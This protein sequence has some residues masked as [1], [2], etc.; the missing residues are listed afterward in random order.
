MKRLTYVVA[1]VAIGTLSLTAGCGAPNASASLAKPVATPP[2]AAASQSSAETQPAA[3]APAVEQLA[4]FFTQSQ[5]MDVRLRHAA[6]L[7]N[8]GFIGQT[9]Q[10]DRA[11][12]AA[13]RDI[14]PL[15]LVRTIPGGLDRDLQRSILLVYN[16]LVSRRAA[17]NGVIEYASTRPLRRDGAEARELLACLANGS[18]AAA[19]F[20]KHLAAARTAASA[21]TLTA[22]APSS[23]QTAEVAILATYI[24]GFN[25]GCASC[26][27]QV[28]GD[29]PPVTWKNTTQLGTR[30]DGTVGNILFQ[31]RYQA[32]QDWTINLNAC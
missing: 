31:A 15:T 19:T 28:L 14:E 2:P 27:G 24:Y 29:L 23:R 7:I 16:D 21:A 22:A 3:P 10:M 9:V 1:A 12:I 18:R 11:S 20:K 30:Y 17:M 32:T 6:S 4:G 13:I 25:N 26:G 5:Q 8:A